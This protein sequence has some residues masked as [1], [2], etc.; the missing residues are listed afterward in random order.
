MNTV[1]VLIVLVIADGTEREWNSY[2]RFQECMEVVKIITKNH[3]SQIQ[4]RCKAKVRSTTQ[5]DPK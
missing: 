1:W 5:G 4:A 2:T 3:E